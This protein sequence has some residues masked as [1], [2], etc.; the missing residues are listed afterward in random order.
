MKTTLALAAL[1][2]LTSSASAADR[3]VEQRPVAAFSSID[4][5]GPYRVVVHAKGTP[6]LR[7]EGEAATLARIET[8]LRGDT[9]VV[10]TQPRDRSWFSFGSER[11]EVL[12][13]ITA[14]A[15]QH[16]KA[17]GSGDVAV[18]LLEGADVELANSGPGDLRASGAVSTLRLRSSGSGDVDLRALASRSLDVAMSGP[19]DVTLGAVDGELA[20]SV[21]GSGD[22]AAHDLKLVRATVRQNGPGNVR[23]PRATCKW[24]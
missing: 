23:L 9:L 7:L 13:T 8:T 21:S 24:S 22:L 11:S 6:G 10:R 15:L 16:V 3:I 2:M 14:A 12:I 4:V 17:S 1:A 5:S 19:G 20:A 18:D